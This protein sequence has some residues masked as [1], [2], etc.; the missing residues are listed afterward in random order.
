MIIIS[1]S[2]RVR[3]D[4]IEDARAALLEMQSVSRAEDGCHTYAFAW[5]LEDPNL[6]RLYEEWE[7]DEALQVHAA[8]DH[9]ATFLRATG[10]M[11]DGG[12]EFK[13]FINAEPA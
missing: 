12:A 2:F 7:S 5:D 13:R 8:T 4:A 10:P 1:G 3:D 9:M 11:M 6:V